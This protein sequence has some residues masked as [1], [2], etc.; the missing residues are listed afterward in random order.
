M[1]RIL[2]TGATGLLGQNLVLELLRQDGGNRLCV[3]GRDRPGLPIAARIARI[4]T[5]DVLC[6]PGDLDQ[7]G[8]GLSPDSLRAL[9]DFAPEVVVHCA[10]A[11]SFNGDESARRSVL[12]TN[13]DGLRALL[14]CT[15]QLRPSRFVFVGSAYSAGRL[16]GLVEPDDLELGGSFANPYQHSKAQAEALVRAWSARTKIPTLVFRPATIAGRLLEEP[17]GATSKY[18]VF[19]GFAK[20]LLLRKARLRRTWDGIFDEPMDMPCRVHVNLGSG[21]NIV[22][23]DYCAKILRHACMA[24]V[25]AGSYH[26]ANPSLTPH[27]AYISAIVERL[28][29]RGF[30]LVSSPP[31]D[32]NDHEIWYYRTL[33]PLFDM[34]VIP[35]P[36][37]FG[38]ESVLALERDANVTCP[39]VG[40]PQLDILLDYAIGHR[41][42]LAAPGSGLPRMYG[43]GVESETARVTSSTPVAPPREERVSSRPW[44]HTPGRH[45]RHERTSIQPRARFGGACGRGGSASSPW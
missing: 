33:A 18:D 21:L 37:R 44:A 1:P 6:L 13:V 10:G 5:G 26:L 23:V 3:L 24:D 32:P 40:G 11:T 36:L 29:I 35:P 41:F 9:Q 45:D 12:R 43:G 28:A 22:P 8:L 27:G 16:S 38:R 4:V 2:L 30:E 25:A 14:A 39:P 17:L 31:S 15:E 34:Y 20:A 42:G 19:Y 7:P